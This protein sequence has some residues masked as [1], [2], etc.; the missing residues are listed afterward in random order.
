MRRITLLAAAMALIAMACS[1]AETETFSPDPEED[2]IAAMSAQ[3]MEDPDRPYDDDAVSCISQ[4]I[5]DE[6]GV[7]GLAELGVTAQYPELQGSSVFATPETARR[8]VDVG[9][10]CIDMSAAITSFLPKDVGLLEESVQC[11]AEQM[12]NDQFS[13]LFASLVVAGGDPADIFTSPAAQLPIAA[14]F[15][16]CLSAEEMFGI[17]DL[18]N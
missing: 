5:V 8:A 7:D 1:G 11:L 17:A 3:A 13:D 15:L 12:Q 14:L 9:M 2:L 16:R 18:L 4:G 6:F 10:S